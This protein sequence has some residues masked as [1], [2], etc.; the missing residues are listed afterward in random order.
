MKKIYVFLFSLSVLSAGLYVY[1]QDEENEQ[2]KEVNTQP[3]ATIQATKRLLISLDTELT[4]LQ[5]SISEH[6]ERLAGV[7]AKWKRE[8]KIK[9]AEQWNQ[10]RSGINTIL[11]EIKITTQDFDHIEKLRRNKELFE[12]LTKLNTESQKITPKAGDIQYIMQLSSLYGKSIFNDK[13]LEKIKS[14]LKIEEPKEK[15]DETEQFK[16]EAYPYEEPAFEEYGQFGGFDDGSFD[17]AD[18]GFGYDFDDSEFGD[19]IYF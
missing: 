4:N 8:G 18:S 10:I 7:F 2:K 14:M 12:M 17:D 15:K 3:V 13:L 19:E 6:S 1:S 9:Q 11:S 5:K 16:F